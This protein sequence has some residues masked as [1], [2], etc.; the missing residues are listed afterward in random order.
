M[1]KSSNSYEQLMNND[2]INDSSASKCIKEQ[3]KRNKK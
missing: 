2:D 1:I 3:V